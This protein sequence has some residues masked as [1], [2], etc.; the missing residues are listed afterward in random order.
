MLF[1]GLHL[2]SVMFS[3]QLVVLNLLGIMAPCDNPIKS[4]GKC[5]LALTEL[6][7]LFQGLPRPSE[8]LHLPCESLSAYSNKVLTKLSF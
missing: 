2:L 5:T 7:I 1:S 4:M 6:Y 8:F 3:F